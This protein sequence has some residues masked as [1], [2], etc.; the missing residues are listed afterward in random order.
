[1]VGFLTR[2][3]IERR[4]R[5]DF[6][7]P[8]TGIK[9]RVKNGKRSSWVSGKKSKKAAGP[10]WRVLPESVILAVP[11]RIQQFKWK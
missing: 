1:V 7:V 6:F 5:G 11:F 3:T 4:L 10:K 2:A 9:R 8:A